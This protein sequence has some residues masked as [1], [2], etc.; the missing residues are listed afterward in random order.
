MSGFRTDIKNVFRYYTQNQMKLV[1]YTRVFLFGLWMFT[2]TSINCSIIFS[3]DR[4]FQQAVHLFLKRSS[5]LIAHMTFRSSLWVLTVSFKI[6]Q[7]FLITTPSGIAHLTFWFDLWMLT[8][9]SSKLFSYCSS[10]VIWD[11][12]QYLSVWSMSPY[13]HF[14]QLFCYFLV[15]AVIFN[16]H[17][18]FRSAR[19]RQPNL[20][21]WKGQRARA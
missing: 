11:T 13:H 7:L 5:S 21:R 12:P 8:V 14:Q 16:S 20:L 6:V 4:H 18:M 10:A 2:V 1:Y 15:T 9:T 17:N 3:N 19:T